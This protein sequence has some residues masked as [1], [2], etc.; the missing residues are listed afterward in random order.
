MRN[1]LHDEQIVLE[2]EEVL[3]LEKENEKYFFKTP[4]NFCT[5]KSRVEIVIKQKDELMSELTL[6]AKPLMPTQIFD[7]GYHRRLFGRIKK[8]LVG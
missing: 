2:R 4:L 8:Q 7:F 3:V 6:R 1:I 5:I